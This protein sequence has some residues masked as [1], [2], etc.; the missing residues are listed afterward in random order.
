ND[1]L[2]RDDKTNI[3]IDI[4]PFEPERLETLWS[5]LP[6][7]RVGRGVRRWIGATGP[8]LQWFPEGDEGDA[9]VIERYGRDKRVG[10]G[11][12]RWMR[13]FPEDDEGD[14]KVIERYGRNKRMIEVLA[15]GYGFVPVFVWQPIPW[16]KYDLKYHLF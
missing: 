3:T 6:L 5:N 11:V 9:K 16:Y 8:F 14:A 12:P 4:E 15:G 13:R 7:V 1:F 10:R 2:V